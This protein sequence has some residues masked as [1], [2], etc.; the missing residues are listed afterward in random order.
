MGVGKR[1][2]HCVVGGVAELH[3]MLVAQEKATRE[4]LSFLNERQHILE[5]SCK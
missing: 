1:K 3:P 5:L 2:V 4:E